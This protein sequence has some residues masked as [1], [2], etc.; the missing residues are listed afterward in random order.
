MMTTTKNR[1]GFTLMEVMAC[2]VIISIVSSITLPAIENFHS[3][4]RVKADATLLVSAIRHAK[5]TA[6]QDNVLIRIIFNEDGSCFKEQLY[7][8]EKDPPKTLTKTIGEDY[9]NILANLTNSNYEDGFEWESLDD[10]A[11]ET[12]FSSGTEVDVTEMQ[13]NGGVLGDVG[14]V[15]YFMPD[16]YIYNTT[17]QKL[18]E[19]RIMFKYGS[20]ALA[21]DVNAL[22]VISSEAFA[23]N[24]DED[25]SE[26][27][28]VEW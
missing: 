7:I 14:G 4:D 10:N 3:A 9:T 1:R 24:E 12:A 26:D 25:Y 28:D 18:P 6:L 5:Y 16:G 8:A 17:A 22:G 2:M 15:I 27:E 23:R 19:I 11:E 20:S 21:V 13:G